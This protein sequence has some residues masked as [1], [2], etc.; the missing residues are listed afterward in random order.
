MACLQCLI[1]IIKIMQNITHS[2][3]YS[4]GFVTIGRTDAFTCGTDFVFA[5]ERFVCSVKS[6]VGRQDKMGALADVQ[7]VLQ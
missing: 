3:A 1:L 6:A 2:D 7:S 5:F 4:G